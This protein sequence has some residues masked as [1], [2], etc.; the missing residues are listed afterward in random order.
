MQGDPARKVPD[1]LSVLFPPVLLENAFQGDTAAESE[2]WR[3][4]HTALRGFT[5][6]LVK[7]YGLPNADIDDFVQTAI[8]R[9]CRRPPEELLQVRNW[10]GW[11]FQ[12]VRN[13]VFDAGR[14]K[15]TGPELLSLSAS[16]DP[17][18]GE[19][20]DRTLE[21]NLA[22]DTPDAAAQVI[23]RE[24]REFLEE[25][26]C[27]LPKEKERVFRLYLEGVK[28]REIA[29]MTGMPVDTVSVWIFRMKRELMNRS[30][31]KTQG[32]RNHGH[33]GSPD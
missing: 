32:T 9:V 10:S 29:V 33:R 16:P 22:A 26:I 20:S 24:L 23:T 11:L 6:I 28:H 1:E 2:L 14:R 15:R 25:F 12:I 18:N 5:V 19:G 13:L 31:S 3:R 4:V 7:R 8:L 21:D 27:S 17:A 30:T